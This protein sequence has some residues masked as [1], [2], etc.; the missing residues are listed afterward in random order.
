M[1]YKDVKYDLVHHPFPSTFRNI[2]LENVHCNIADEIGIDIR[3]L[4]VSKVEN[5]S[6]K[7]VQIQETN[8]SFKLDHV[9]NIMFEHVNI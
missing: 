2:H 5:V 8:T 1:E 9:K 3:G 6:L 7:N 4:E